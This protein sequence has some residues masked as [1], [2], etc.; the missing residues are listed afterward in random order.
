MRQR[1][2]CIIRLTPAPS[3]DV[4]LETLCRT[5]YQASHSDPAGGWERVIFSPQVA[6]GILPPSHLH[7]FVHVPEW[8]NGLPQ[9]LPWQRSPV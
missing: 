6:T 9:H 3:S 4:L 5:M 7:N 8:L 2:S 1:Q